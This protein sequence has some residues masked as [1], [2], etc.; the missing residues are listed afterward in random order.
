MKAKISVRKTRDLVACELIHSVSMPFDEFPPTSHIF[1]IASVRGY[2]A[3]YVSGTP[4]PGHKDFFVSCAAVAPEFRGMGV[5]V[6]MTKVQIAYA[7]RIGAEWIHTYTMRDNVAS[8]SNYQKCG[9]HY[10]EPEHA[11]V[12][13]KNVLYW[14]LKL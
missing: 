2:F 7:R 11:Y 8:Y 1:W 6:S 10:F 12:G 9:F 5:H 3:G 4:S 14:R 13:R